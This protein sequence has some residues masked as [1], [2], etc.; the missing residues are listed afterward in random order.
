MALRIW[1][2]ESPACRRLSVVAA[3]L[4]GALGGS[5]RAGAAEWSGEARFSFVDPNVTIQRYSETTSEEAVA[6]LPVF[7]G[8]RVWTDRSGR[9]DIQFPDG[10]FL[11]VGPESRLDVE[12]IEDDNGR[13]V[14]RLWSGSVVVGRVDNREAYDFQILTE[15]GRAVIER[16]GL[17]R[18]DAN[19][20]ETRVAVLEGEG[21]AE[22]ADRRREIEAGSESWMRN[23]YEPTGAREADERYADAL[24]AWAAERW[25]QLD[26]RS[27][28]RQYLPDSLYAY[29]SDFDTNGTWRNEAGV[30]YVWCPRVSAGWQP[31][32]QGRWCWTPYGWNWV[33]AEPW[34]WTVSHYGS[35]D[36]SVGFGWYWLPGRNWGPAHVVWG[37][38]GQYVGW[39]PRGR[40]GRA[41][42]FGHGGRFGGH[43]G[44]HD[45]LGAHWT[46]VGSGDMRHRDISR[47]RIDHAILRSDAV[48][49]ADSPRM[50]PSRDGRQLV[51]APSINS[52]RAE[53]RQPRAR[54]NPSDTPGG[55][56]GRQTAEA[57]SWSNGR[58]RSPFGDPST[59]S[60]GR[61]P[62]RPY[63][64]ENREVASTVPA[65]ENG[66]A[67]AQPRRPSMRPQSFGS[68][69]GRTGDE[70]RG[71]YRTRETPQREPVR[72]PRADSDGWVRSQPRQ[73]SEAP[74]ER[75]RVERSRP[76]SD[77]ERWR[78][79]RSDA[80]T[81]A[82]ERT[83]SRR[84]TP[85]PN[86]DNES[87]RSQPRQRSEA[88]AERPRVERSR[89]S[90]QPRSER[91]EAPVRV[92]RQEAPSR[93]Q[94]ESGPRGHDRSSSSGGG[95]ER[96]GGA[97]RRGGE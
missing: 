57:P 76:S 52:I 74:A 94:S 33:P 25:R 91:R 78:S 84:E 29:G 70:S 64:N 55:Q 56:W 24:D 54:G 90:E 63:S 44:D 12:T 32:R 31:Y 46:F 5:T 16:H 80:Q 17:V 35:W 65:S 96:G 89:P 7:S 14:V 2:P 37:Q 6:N 22:S 21:E 27:E 41:V 77:E 47:V 72:V 28:S 86:S 83:D 88:P 73:R 4:L 53:L 85:R 48:R 71:D 19:A 93:S 97:R 39:C 10:S 8:D 20:G 40:N 18:V 92:E 61:Q 38:S 60:L 26:Y 82:P 51:A 13:A 36:F 58:R 62:R 43:S 15:A 30:G 69:D 1:R 50:A 66:G 67:H 79:S 49:I 87:V 59:G 11:L 34:G 81:R 42:D 23:G 68:E 3:V 9:A 95:N 75:P 45:S